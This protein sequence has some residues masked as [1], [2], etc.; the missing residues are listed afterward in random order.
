MKTTTAMY[1]KN[2]IISTKLRFSLLTGAIT[3]LSFVNVH[4]Q[5]SVED[6]FKSISTSEDLAG[7]SISCMFMEVLSNDVVFSHQPDLLLTPASTMKVLVTRTALE[8]FGPDHQFE[9]EVWQ[10][11]TISNG[12]LNGNIVIRGYGDPT[13]G[14]PN[15]KKQDLLSE[16]VLILKK[17]GINSISGKIILDEEYFSGEPLAGSTPIADGGNYYA[18]GVHG[19]NYLD[20][21]AEVT[22]SSGT[23]SGS[24]VRITSIFP[25][26]PGMEFISEVEA[27]ESKQDNAYIFGQPFDQRRYIRGTIPKGQ[28]AFKIKAA[29]SH[30]AESLGQAFVDL[31]NAKGI[32]VADGWEI[33][34]QTTITSGESLLHSEKS[35]PLSEII[36]FTNRK[37]INLYAACLLKHIGMKVSGVGSFESGAEAITLFWQSKGMNTKGLQIKD[38]SGLSRANNIS[39]RQLAFVST[40]IGEAKEAEYLRSLRP[41]EGRGSL[42]VKSGY[43]DRVRAYTGR[44]TLHDGHEVAFAVIINNYGCTATE[45]NRILKKFLKTITKE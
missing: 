12:T 13:L 17:A 43:I 3:V 16:W 27:S 39:T 14:S 40:Y 20:N 19:L 29:M 34:E 25:E 6:A 11:G 18:A 22:L 45:A 35:P 26:I 28:K 33:A 30:P 7:A 23:T 9:T 1:F 38:G 31:L 15:F 5:S 8:M 37:S 44:T 4:A 2:S 21:T 10:Q 42:L 32:K 41:F 36:Y 24:S